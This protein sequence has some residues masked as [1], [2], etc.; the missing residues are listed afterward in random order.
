MKKEYGMLIYIYLKSTHI[1]ALLLALSI[2]SF[3]RI[4]TLRKNFYHYFLSS[5]SVCLDVIN[6]TWTPMYELVN[7]FEVLNN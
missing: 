4:S 5:G 6:Q 1:K 3:I 2:K 7:V